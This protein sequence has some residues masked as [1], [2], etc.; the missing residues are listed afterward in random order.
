MP[1]LAQLVVTNDAGHLAS[2]VMTGAWFETP[3]L[4]HSSPRQWV[5][6]AYPSGFPARFSLEK[7]YTKFFKPIIGAF[8]QSL[9]FKFHLSI[10]FSKATM[11]TII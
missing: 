5:F 9:L 2:S 11:S 4:S 6:Q 3:S 7:R 10:Q 8:P 1:R